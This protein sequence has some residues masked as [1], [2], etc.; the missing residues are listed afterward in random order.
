MLKNRDLKCDLVWVEL[1]YS[2]EGA[3][4][5]STL[6]FMWD[7][8]LMDRAWRNCFSYGQTMIYRFILLIWLFFLFA[9]MM[10]LYTYITY[11]YLYI[12]FMYCLTK[13]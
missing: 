4:L 6:S 2:E 9:D 11:M 3:I 10:I 1:E 12:Y 13:G 8:D 7:T 5:F